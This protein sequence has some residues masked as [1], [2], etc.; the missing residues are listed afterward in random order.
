VQSRPRPRQSGIESVKPGLTL[1][2]DRR[3]S[4]ANGAGRCRDCLKPLVWPCSRRR[5]PLA[6]RILTDAVPISRRALPSSKR[7]LRVDRLLD[8]HQPRAHH[9]YIGVRTLGLVS[10]GAAAVVCRGAQPNRRNRCRRPSS[11]ASYERLSM[12]SA[13][14]VS[15]HRVTWSFAELPSAARQW[16]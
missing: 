12:R 4:W 5:G 6:L 10:L 14:S 16:R 1:K 13:S 3:A 15:R 7:Q 11:G 2:R 8:R 9:R